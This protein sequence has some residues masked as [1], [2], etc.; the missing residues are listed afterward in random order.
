MIDI[1]KVEL[2]YVKGAPVNLS[3]TMGD[4]KT[5]I[6]FELWATWC[7]PC[8]TTIPHLTDLQKKYE[9]QNV[10]FI[11]ISSEPA[12]KIK[13]FVEQMGNEMDYR[14]ASDPDDFSME[15]MQQ[16]GVKGI[17][18]AFIIGKNG[19]MTF[20]D[21]PQNPQFEKEIQKAI[22]VPDKVNVID[23]K[24]MTRD[25]LANTPVKDLKAYLKSVNID[26]TGVAEKSELIDLILK[27]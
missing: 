13:P 19:K 20:H 8:R 27:Q 4:G 10:I 3:K 25:Q 17:P 7:G 18:H 21:H 23:A 16:C 2:E 5:V 22:E 12:K 26:I 9:K 6:I 11:G 24:S 15:L 1:S 14:V